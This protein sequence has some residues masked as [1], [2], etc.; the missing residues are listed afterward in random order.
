MHSKSGKAETCV[1]LTLALA[2]GMLAAAAIAS[3]PWSAPSASANG[4]VVPVKEGV[5]GPYGYVVGIWPPAP[6]V[7]NLFM[8]ITLSADGEPV[9]DA[10][11]DV[12][13]GPRGMPSRVGPLPANNDFLHPPTYELDV[14]L[15]APG[16]WVFRISIRAPLGEEDVE[17]ELDV[18]GGPDAPPILETGSQG[19]PPAEAQVADGSDASRD[20]GLPVAVSIAAVVAAL[21]VAAGAGAWVVLRRRR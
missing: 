5:A 3:N 18:A 2:V 9:I 7:G 14:S 8:A 13:G 19:D 11:V 17:V 10:V 21:A 1:S 12:E 15:G 16:P 4:I 6:A 20:A